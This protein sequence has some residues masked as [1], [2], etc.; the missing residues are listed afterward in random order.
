VTATTRAQLLW[1]FLGAYYLCFALVIGLR[2][3]QPGLARAAL[4][5]G[6][7]VL[8]LAAALAGI[9][10]AVDGVRAR[11]RRLMDFMRSPEFSVEK[12]KGRFI[13]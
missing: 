4:G 12:L 9:E 1:L 10:P 2:R 7:V 13:E 11:E 3:I 8:G 5:T 6:A